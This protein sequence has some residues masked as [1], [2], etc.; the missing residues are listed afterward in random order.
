MVGQF[1]TKSAAI[2]A[3]AARG[4]MLCIVTFYSLMILL[5][6]SILLK[7]SLLALGEKF[8][9]CYNQRDGCL[10]IQTL[11]RLVEYCHNVG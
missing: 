4:C 10:E 5:K 11:C 6:C 9:V 8:I 1:L 2:L 3:R 7:T